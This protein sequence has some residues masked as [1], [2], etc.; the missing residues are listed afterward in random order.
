M[1]RFTRESL[2]GDMDTLVYK[3][4][5]MESSE[6]GVMANGCQPKVVLIEGALGVGK[7]TFAWW[8]CRQWAE[9]KLLQVY[10]PLCYCCPS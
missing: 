7:T 8:Q 9:A 4:T 3:K 1:D 2:R 6:L 5:A 10:T